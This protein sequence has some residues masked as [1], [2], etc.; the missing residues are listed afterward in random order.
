MEIHS[1]IRKIDLRSQCWFGAGKESHV[2]LLSEALPLCWEKQPV[3]PLFQDLS[4]FVADILQLGWRM[5]EPL[6]SQSAETEISFPR[7][8]FNR[9]PGLQ[10][11]TVS[12]SVWPSPEG[13][14]TGSCA[15]GA[16]RDLRG[17][18]VSMFLF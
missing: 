14:L 13:V 4:S 3:S 15:N 2:Y 18:C 5:W 7:H 6:S 11:E 17:Q 16:T 10:N 9:A 8:Q 1:L 12:M